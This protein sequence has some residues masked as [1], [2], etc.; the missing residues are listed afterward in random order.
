M[1]TTCTY[2]AFNSKYLFHTFNIPLLYAIETRCGELNA[3]YFFNKM[4]LYNSI[5]PYDNGIL[6]V[7]IFVDKPSAINRS[8]FTS[9]CGSINKPYQ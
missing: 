7:I 3:L 4:I 6:S 9:I 2:F 5:V 8:I 1:P